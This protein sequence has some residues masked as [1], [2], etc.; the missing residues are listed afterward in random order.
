[1]A[2]IQSFRG[3]LFHQALDEIGKKKLPFGGKSDA[4]LLDDKL[5]GTVN[6]QIPGPEDGEYTGQP[7]FLDVYM[8]IMPYLKDTNFNDAKTSIENAQLIFG[9]KSDAELLDDKMSGKVSDQLTPASTYLAVDTPVYI[10]VYKAKIPN[11]VGSDLE[12]AKTDIWN[13]GLTADVKYLDP[14]ETGK[15]YIVDSLLKPDGTGASAGAILPA[16][17]IITINAKVKETV[18]RIP[19]IEDVPVAT[20][21]REIYIPHHDPDPDPLR[22]AGE[23]MRIDLEEKARIDLGERMQIDPGLKATELSVDKMKLAGKKRIIR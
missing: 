4:E 22:D 9:G 15:D 2:P 13:A 21:W 16:G 23:R 19:R 11:L 18:T 14:V 17:T 8:T 12:K 20:D 7:I 5:A 6:D 3:M 10:D 1:M